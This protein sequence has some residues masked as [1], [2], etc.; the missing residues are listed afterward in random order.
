M[1]VTADEFT[2][3]DSGVCGKPGGNRDKA[4]CLSIFREHRDLADELVR[5]KE[6]QEAVERAVEIIARALRNSCQ[7]LFCGNGGSAADA[8]HLSLLTLRFSMP[9]AR[10]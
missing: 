3:L 8:Q 2:D 9:P 7:V 6:L 10:F 5:D 4:D 1:A